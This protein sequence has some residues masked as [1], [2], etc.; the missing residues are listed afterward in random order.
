MAF[1][2][3]NN[4]NLTFNQVWYVDAITGQDVGNLGSRTSPFKT[5]DKALEMASDGD[6]IYLMGKVETEYYSTNTSLSFTK[7]ISLIGDAENTILRVEQG[8]SEFRS[9][10]ANVSFYRMR[11][12][13]HEILRS[14][15]TAKKYNFYNC[16]IDLTI[17]L[18]GY[19]AAS[20]SLYF[21]NCHFSDELDSGGYGW[22]RDD[23]TM[24]NCIIQGLIGNMSEYGYVQ[25]NNTLV[26]DKFFASGVIRNFSWKN[27]PI[28]EPN[29]FYRLA[30][31]E[32]KGA[33]VGLNP[34]GTQAELGLY[35]GPYAWGTWVRP[36]NVFK[37]GSQYFTVKDDEI[38]LLD[39]LKYDEGTETPTDLFKRRTIRVVNQVSDAMTFDLK[40]PKNAQI[41]RG[42]E[43]YLQDTF[44]LV[45][46]SSQA[47]LIH[48][49]AASYN[50]FD[51][52]LQN[53]GTLHKSNVTY[54]GQDYTDLQGKVIVAYTIIGNSSGSFAATAW[55]FEGS[56]DGTNWAHLHRISE[57]GS[58]ANYKART[59][60]VPR[61]R[62]KKYNQYRIRFEATSSIYI[63]EAIFYEG[64]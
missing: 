25:A 40:N 19:P 27:R 2:T 64:V 60:W 48:S 50:F 58:W 21:Y 44:S 52:T 32:Y 41:T 1:V 9:A 56:D 37:V 23:C 34:D 43:G 33:G 47:Y 20:N 10:R 14:S 62:I 22:Y 36:K 57:T 49:S 45:D 4:E 46:V 54:V 31:P 24:T 16:Y 53:G 38:K 18:V 30:M 6:A 15:N 8:K 55:N 51:K 29:E 35:G 42:N 28:L 26:N 7:D 61:E 11:I 13:G 12:V 3:I 17:K 5:I 59:Y 39:E 63:A